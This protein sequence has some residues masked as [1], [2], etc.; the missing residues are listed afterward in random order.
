MQFNLMKIVLSALIKIS[1]IKTNCILK[2]NTFPIS[3]LFES[4]KK[5]KN[6]TCIGDSNQLEPR[7]G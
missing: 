1:R 5:E 7:K 3:Y 6:E 4:K 2:T